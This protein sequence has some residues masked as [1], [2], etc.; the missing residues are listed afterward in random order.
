MKHYTSVKAICP[1]YRHEGSQVIYCDGV[2]Y[3][4][5]THLAFASKTD[6]LAYKEKYCRA[7]YPLCNIY[8]MLKEITR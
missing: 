1:Y 7:D 6:A 2:V 5:V 4:S 8:K 3:G